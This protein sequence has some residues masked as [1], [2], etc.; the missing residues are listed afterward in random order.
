DIVYA[1]DNEKFGS[2]VSR[3]NTGP[4][5][6]EE[7][8]LRRAD[9]SL[10]YVEGSF[11]KMK[12]PEGKS[13]LIFNGRDITK[14]R[15]AEQRMRESE[16]MYRALFESSPDGI[17][18]VKGTIEECNGRITEMLGYSK[19][20][21]L[22]KTL[23]ELV[24]EQPGDV[25][26]QMAKARGV[27]PVEG[28]GPWKHKKGRSVVLKVSVRRVMLRGE[29]H[30]L[31]NFMSPSNE[32]VV[33]TKGGELEQTCHAILASSQDAVL[34][35]APSLD[36]RMASAKAKV[37]FGPETETRSLFDV[38]RSSD[39]GL[40]SYLKA[41]HD[42]ERLQPY[43]MRLPSGSG[44]T[45]VQMTGSRISAGEGSSE[46]IILILRDITD[47][48]LAEEH[49]IVTQ[50]TARE[51]NDLFRI[52]VEKRVAALSGHLQ[53]LQFKMR[54]EMERKQVEMAL[55][56][57]S[58]LLRFLDNTR[59][60]QMVRTK[61]PAWI[62]L[63]DALDASIRQMD[64]NGTRLDDQIEDL[65][66][67]A[68]MMFPSALTQLLRHQLSRGG[69]L[70]SLSLRTETDAAGM[71]IIIQDDGIPY[72]PQDLERLFELDGSGRGLRFVKEVCNASRMK[73]EGRCLEEGMIF[74]IHAPEGTFRRR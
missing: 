46:G 72:K 54:G 23:M 60:L 17:M 11:S 53:L 69:K 58:G 22:G 62:P 9:G 19:E 32:T 35:L 18:L 20:E 40:V 57:T 33:E 5:E 3:G 27:G 4:S 26:Q 48:V 36:V 10:S 28:T 38:L 56:Q 47:N 7:F 45:Y 29:Q 16:E 61:P 71:R 73:V 66:L 41:V 52:E 13:S 15:L 30:H 64:L 49:T 37:M 8:R 63:R 67:L 65:E 12:D 2:I 55:D 43:R 51:L 68:D 74:M 31:L 25:L 34:V 1:E 39:D 44:M 6:L 14:R 21:L 42:G 50:E 70:R 24:I 59:E